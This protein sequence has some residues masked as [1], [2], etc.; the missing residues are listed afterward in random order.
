MIE[1]TDKTQG[2]HE[3]EK[4]VDRQR[5]TKL[6]NRRNYLTPRTLLTIFPIDFFDVL[7]P[8]NAMEV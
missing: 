3:S 5:K 7:L 4:G 6:N 1:G 2:S 8:L